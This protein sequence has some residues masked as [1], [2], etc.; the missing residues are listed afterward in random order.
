[1]EL[2]PQ[3]LKNTH[4][5]FPNTHGTITETDQVRKHKSYNISKNR[6]QVDLT[7]TIILPSFKFIKDFSLSLIH[8]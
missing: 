4:F 1:M 7:L 3:Q 5:F 2:H 6:Y 8:F